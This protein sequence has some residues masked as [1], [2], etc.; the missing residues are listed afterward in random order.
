M[1][2]KALR[3][4]KADLVTRG[5]MWIVAGNA[6]DARV[7]SDETLAQFEAIRLKAHVRWAAP[8]V[9]HR[10]VEGAVALSAQVGNM[11]RIE[12]FQGLR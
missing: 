3:V 5:L 11:F 2:S 8:V 4:I 9:A 1:T 6:A 7:A 12:V 10:A